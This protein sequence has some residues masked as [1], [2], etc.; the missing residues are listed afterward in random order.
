ML[1]RKTSLSYSYMV[2]CLNNMTS[3]NPSISS[4]NSD[5]M[6]ELK[7]FFLNN[8]WLVDYNKLELLMNSNWIRI[9]YWLEIYHTRLGMI[10]MTVNNNGLG[11][12]LIYVNTMFRLYYKVV[13]LIFFVQTMGAWWFTELRQKLLCRSGSA[14]DNHMTISLDL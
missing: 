3:E 10:L 5:N 11:E 2:V 12:I 4:W 7:K 9:V 6:F 13:Q 1:A 8:T 14:L